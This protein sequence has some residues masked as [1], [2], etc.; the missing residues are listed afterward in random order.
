MTDCPHAEVAIDRKH[1]ECVIEG[2]NLVIRARAR[3]IECGELA[4]AYLVNESDGDFIYQVKGEDDT[5]AERIK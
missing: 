1:L 3:C 5:R 2:M 4:W